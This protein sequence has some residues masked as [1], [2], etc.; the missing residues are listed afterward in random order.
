MGEILCPYCKAAVSGG[1]DV[2]RCLQCGTRHHRVCWL[3]YGNHCSVFSCQGKFV[4]FRNN[5]RSNIILIIWCLV[6]YALHLGLRFI[7]EVTDSFALSDV[8]IVVVMEIIVIGTGL[9]AVRTRV[10]S[11]SVRTVSLLL[12]SANTLFVSL[13]FSHYVTH[14]LEQLN[15]LIRL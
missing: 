3:E 10:S 7:G 5:T 11:E 4:G 9:M 14:G 1:S 15:A 2:I 8:F 13:L 12:F 6:N